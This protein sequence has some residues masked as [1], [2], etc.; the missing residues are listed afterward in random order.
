MM[1]T[2]KSYLRSHFETLAMFDVVAI[3]DALEMFADLLSGQ[4]NVGLTLCGPINFTKFFPSGPIF[5][6]TDFCTFLLT[7]AA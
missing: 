1:V 6:S 2:G 4:R 3:F 5:F 7:L